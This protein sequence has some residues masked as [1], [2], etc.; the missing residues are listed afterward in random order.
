MGR[1]K[2]WVQRPAILFAGGGKNLDAQP[3]GHEVK[4]NN[5]PRAKRT[6]RGCLAAAGPIRRGRAA[7]FPSGGPT[8]RHS[9]LRRIKDM[10]G[11]DVL[12]LAVATVMGW[13]A[14]AVASSPASPRG[15]PPDPKADAP[16]VARLIQQLGSDR[17]RERED[18]SQALEAIGEPAWAALTDAAAGSED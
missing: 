7:V 4:H 18:A 11:R 8:V 1:A 17:F 14:G 3:T 2:C 10:A 5:N 16:T 9:G 15:E 6:D 13:A 12:T